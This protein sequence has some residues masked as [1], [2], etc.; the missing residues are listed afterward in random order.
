MLLLFH[1]YVPFVPVRVRVDAR[2]GTSP[3]P[4]IVVYLRTPRLFAIVET[5]FFLR[6]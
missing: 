5:R 3:L 6:S 2:D 1:Y 4:I